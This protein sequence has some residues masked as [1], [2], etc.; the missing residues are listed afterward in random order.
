[1]FLSNVAIKQAF[2]NAIEE[3]GFLDSSSSGSPFGASFHGYPL[4][5]RVEAARLLPTVCA[6]SWIFTGA[7]VECALMSLKIQRASSFSYLVFR[8]AEK[9]NKARPDFFCPFIYDM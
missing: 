7:V 9:L 4:P 8:E 3:S 5:I 6:L 1:M 2:G